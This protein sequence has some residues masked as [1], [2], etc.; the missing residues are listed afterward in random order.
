M[1]AAEKAAAGQLGADLNDELTIIFN[2]V[3]AAARGLDPVDP[4]RKHLAVISGA[5][6]RCAWKTAELVKIGG[7]MRARH[8]HS[9]AVAI[10]DGVGLFHPSVIER[11][12]R[13]LQGPKEEA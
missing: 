2:S 8:C 6:R 13:Q 5:A 3:D 11:M 4:L 12:L 1:T 7:P 10:P 9:A